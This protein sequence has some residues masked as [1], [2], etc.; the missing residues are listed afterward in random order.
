MGGPG[1]IIRLLKRDDVET[2]VIGEVCEWHECEYVRDCSELGI[3]KT[4]LTL[5]HHMSE[6]EGMKLFNIL[7][8]KM[9]THI[10][11]ATKA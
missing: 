2:V 6:R 7:K 3:Q 5:G 4:I 11:M 1:S 9:F 10:R 8:V